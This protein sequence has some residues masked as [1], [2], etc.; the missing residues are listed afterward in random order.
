MKSKLLII[1]LFCSVFT[2][3]Q[4]SSKSKK[5]DVD[6]NNTDSVPTVVDSLLFY[7]NEMAK[8]DSIIN[9][10]NKRI[11][12]DSS[13]FVDTLMKVSERVKQLDSS[14]VNSQ[15]AL[16][17][18]VALLSELRSTFE[19]ESFYEL[20]LLYP[21]E[22]PYDSVDIAN[23]LSFVDTLHL[24]TKYPTITKKYYDLVKNYGNYRK[25]VARCFYRVVQEFQISGGKPVR[26]RVRDIYNSE[27]QKTQYWKMTKSCG[28]NSP[29]IERYL[30]HVEEL[31]NNPADFKEENFKYVHDRIMRVN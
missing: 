20:I 1:L 4:K 10:L 12:N 14:L 24:N 5:I 22:M 25:E 3:A 9:A 17:D 8:K 13:Y 29:F 18:S 23:R 6:N 26:E 11:Q 15:T 30:E 2:V 21:L 16:K 28:A 31:L 19:S 27:L 7:K